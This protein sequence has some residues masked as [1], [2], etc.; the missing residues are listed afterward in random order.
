MHVLLKIILI[1]LFTS[2]T[3]YANSVATVSALKGDVSLK[4]ENVV[5]KLFLGEKLYKTDS[6]ITAKKSKAQILFTDNTVVTVGKESHFIIAEYLADNGENSS[7]ELG[8]FKGAIR[9]ITGKIGKVA[10]QKFKVKTKTA[11]I[12]IRGTNFTVVHK[13]D[14]EESVYCTYGAIYV[15]VDGVVYEV[16]AGEY[17]H[18]SSMYKVQVKPLS[19]QE[20]Q[21][22]NLEYFLSQNDFKREEYKSDVIY[23]EGMLIDTTQNKES[24]QSGEFASYLQDVFFT[25]NSQSDLSMMSLSGFSVDNSQNF[26]IDSMNSLVNL[27]FL[28]QSNTFDTTN[29]WLEVSNRENWSLSGEF[30][31]WKFI[32]GNDATFSSV[33]LS[34][35]SGSTSSDAI[36]VNSS[37]ITLTD[38]DSD[39][40]MSWGEWDAT[41][42]Y[43]VEQDFNLIN[44]RE[45]FEGL[46]VAGEP[47]DASVI[48]SLN[49]Q[50]NY[51]GEY[52]M[53]DTT[54][55]ISN[56]VSGVAQ[57][58]V[59]FANAEAI[60]FLQDIDYIFNPATITANTLQLSGTTESLN[61]TFYGP[62]AESI[63]GNF[64]IQDPQNLITA[65]G[66]YQVT[67]TP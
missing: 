1:T 60:L 47:T 17:L 35:K 25:Q 37:F 16:K 15:E 52:R 63:G 24:S 9:T 62:N 45:T 65:K 19:A 14:G 54:V 12:G 7:V 6:I 4:N 57:M 61:G 59:D 66:V 44:V 5:K 42:D 22:L 11:T 3:L 30:D 58:S 46:W 51:E 50:V 13:E 41:I 18:I 31:D 10:P 48:S 55:G 36:L 49:T 38:L 8:L 56:T 39:D 27:S 34:A 28:P 21:L 20:L 32:I 23:D 43:K 26:S 33:E 2:V 40:Y 53:F 67:Q 64:A 29:S